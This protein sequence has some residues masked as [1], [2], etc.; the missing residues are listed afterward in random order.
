M[1]DPQTITVDFEDDPQSGSNITCNPAFIPFECNP[2]H[3]AYI[4]SKG[5]DITGTPPGF[6]AMTIIS[7]SAGTTGKVIQYAAPSFAETHDGLSDNEILTIEFLNGPVNHVDVTLTVTPSTGPLINNIPSTVTMTAF[8]ESDNIVTSS[9]VTFTGVTKG[10][11]TPV[12]IITSSSQFDI[13]N[14]TLE[15]DE[16]HVLGGVFIEALEYVQDVEDEVEIDIKPGSDPNSVNCKPNKKG[17]INGVV[18]IG[19]FS[20]NSFDA[21]TIDLTPLTLNGVGTS[22]VHGTLHIEDLNNDGLDDAVIHVSTADICAA[23]TVPEGLE[24]VTVGG[25]N[26]DGQFEGTDTVRIVKR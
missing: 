7:G 10:V 21:T 14:V 15:I 11:L 19:I 9:I 5:I 12:H 1:Q 18:P 16:P 8:D 4:N 25:E 17:D 23:T 6:L 2:S 26:A 24:D 20:S 22:E 3:H 13:A